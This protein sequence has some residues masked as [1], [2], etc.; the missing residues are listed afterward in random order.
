MAVN[1]VELSVEGISDL[2]GMLEQRER[3]V[4]TRAQQIVNT[5]AEYAENEAKAS[6]DAYLAEDA[7]PVNLALRTGRLRESIGHEPSGRM[8]LRPKGRFKARV[9]A[10]AP[11]AGYVEKGTGPVGAASPHPSGMGTYAS[12][13]WMYYN[14]V[15]QRRLV[16]EGFRSRPF[17]WEAHTKTRER[18]HELLREG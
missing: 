14:T 11:Y 5:L 7:S 10:K 8:L 15:L 2:I 16:T 6:L 1:Q 13:E 18:L 4:K 3:N 12:E 9:F 17:M